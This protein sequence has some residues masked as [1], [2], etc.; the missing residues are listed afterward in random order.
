MQC[1]SVSFHV[2]HSSL[3]PLEVHWSSSPG[4]IWIFQQQQN[5][6]DFSLRLLLVFGLQPAGLIPQSPITVVFLLCQSGHYV[7]F[8]SLLYDLLGLLSNPILELA[9]TLYC[10]VLYCTVLYCTVL[11]CTVLYCT[12]L[13]CT[14]LY[15]TV[16]YCTVLYCTVLYCDMM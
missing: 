16:L 6:E 7:G 8:V 5:A 9:P 11:Y 10:T 12:V 2:F 14:V 13:Y 1:L 4:D 15:C 3:V